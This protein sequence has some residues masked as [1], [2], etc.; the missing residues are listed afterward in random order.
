[1]ALNNHKVVPHYSEELGDRI[2]SAVAC[3]TFPLHELV[4]INPDFP[5]AATI[6]LWRR[7]HPDFDAKFIEAKRNQTQLLIDQ[8]I[9]ISDDPANCEPAVLQWAK[10][11]CDNRKWLAIRLLGRIYGN[12]K[13]EDISNDETLSKIQALVADLNKTN[14]SDV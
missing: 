12:Q 8:I 3:S 13:D 5:I 2:C 10:L 14:T 7:V 11:R 1:M 4:A 6:Y 9:E